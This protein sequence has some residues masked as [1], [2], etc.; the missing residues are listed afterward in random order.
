MD[1]VLALAGKEEL[2]RTVEDL[3]GKCTE[4]ENDVES[5]MNGFKMFLSFVETEGAERILELIESKIPDKSEWEAKWREFENK[6]YQYK[7]W[8]ENSDQDM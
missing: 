5:K 4:Q 2:L 8:P 1:I 3:V 7:V 6:Y